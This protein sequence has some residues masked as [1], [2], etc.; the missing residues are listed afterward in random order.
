MHKAEHEAVVTMPSVS[1]VRP[2][3]HQ[4]NPGPVYWASAAAMAC[5]VAAPFP[6]FWAPPLWV[7]ALLA[8]PPSLA[9]LAMVLRGAK[10]KDASTI[11][12][13]AGCPNQ[14][15]R[16]APRTGARCVYGASQ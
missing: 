14:A 12:A 1:Q 15:R 6:F 2:G 3:R 8:P 11:H 7:A 9:V 16:M 5:A 10:P 4:G 13:R